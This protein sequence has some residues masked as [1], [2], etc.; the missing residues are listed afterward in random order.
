MVTVGM[1]YQVLP[2]KEEL[3]ESVF[4]KVLHVMGNLEGHVKTNLYRDV[5][6]AGSY[7]ILSEWTDRGNFDA[8]IASDQFRSVAN[9]GKEQVLATR[10]SHQ[11]YGDAPPPPAA[12]GRCPVAGH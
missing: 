7:M 1:N 2:G 12:A 3:F 8:F 9:W 11:Y 10:P 6:N 4:K 5:D